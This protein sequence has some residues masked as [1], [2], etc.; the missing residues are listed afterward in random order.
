[1]K[2]LT[3]NGEE[4]LSGAT[5]VAGMVKEM[6]LPAPL[7]LIEHNGLALRKSE[8]ESTAIRDGDRIEILRVSAGG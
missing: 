6:G 1:M 7:V 8:W 4:R 5:T 3:I 2:T